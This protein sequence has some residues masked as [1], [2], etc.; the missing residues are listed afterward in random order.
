MPTYAANSSSVL[1]FKVNLETFM[2]IIKCEN[3]R[4]SNKKLVL[5]TNPVRHKAEELEVENCVCY[6]DTISLHY[7]TMRY[8]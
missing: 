1:N 5:Y 3:R 6:A 2:I 4:I 8:E 7:D